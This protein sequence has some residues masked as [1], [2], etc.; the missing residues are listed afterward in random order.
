M[1]HKFTAARG[2]TRRVDRSVVLLKSKEIARQM[3][4]GWQKLLM[5]QDISIILAIH[6]CTLINEEQVGTPQTAH[7]NR[8]HRSRERRTGS[9]SQ[10]NVTCGQVT[11]VSNAVLE[12][13]IFYP[14]CLKI[15]SAIK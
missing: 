4:N 5:K 12:T 14:R 1:F 6:L 3:A 9:H 15:N 10:H 7:N 2:L 11:A 13:E 8:H